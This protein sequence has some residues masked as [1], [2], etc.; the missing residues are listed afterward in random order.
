MSHK[1]YGIYKGLQRPLEF[2]GLQ[3]R[4]IVWGAATGLGSFLLFVIFVIPFGFFVGFLVML[5]SL[6]F[7]ATMI[8]V[9]QRRGLHDKRVYKGIKIVTCLFRI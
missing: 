9:K 7:G 5:L 8:V 6:V 4:Y 1:S 3:G 2:K